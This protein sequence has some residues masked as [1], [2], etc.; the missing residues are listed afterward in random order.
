VPFFGHFYPNNGKPPGP[1][2]IE[3]RPAHLFEDETRKFEIPNTS[4]VEVN[5]KI[6][7]QIITHNLKR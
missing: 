1:W 3:C 2:E 4:H 6:Q 5:K 7:L